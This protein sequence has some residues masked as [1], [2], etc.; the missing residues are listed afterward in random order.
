MFFVV[1]GFG[2]EQVPLFLSFVPR[3][4]VSAEKLLTYCEEH[5]IGV[6]EY[7][8]DSFLTPA[9]IRGKGSIGTT[10]RMKG[11]FVFEFRLK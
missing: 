10:I 8:L 7:A 6:R 5:G 3:S 9:E 2:G 11:A 1:A 4:F